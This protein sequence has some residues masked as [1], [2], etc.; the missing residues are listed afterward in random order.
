M[1]EPPPSRS[2]FWVTMG[3]LLAISGGLLLVRPQW[4][5]PRPPKEAPV[6]KEASLR[7]LM[8]QHI[9]RL[10]RYRRANGHLAPTLADAGSDSF[11][12]Q[13]LPDSAGDRYTLVGESGGHR[14]T[15]TSDVPPMD[16]LGNS[17]QI[18][19]GRPR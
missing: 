9:L 14:I 18:I 6:I 16:F 19:Q 8:Y 5:F 13:Y 11:A 7:L 10:E 2:G 17:Y 1:P 3:L 12:V 4:L 15:Y